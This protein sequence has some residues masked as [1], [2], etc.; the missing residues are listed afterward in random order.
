MLHT[1]LTF[2]IILGVILMFIG[3][4]SAKVVLELSGT[5][6]SVL[7]EALWNRIH[8]NFVYNLYDLG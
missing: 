3:M 1:I 7:D 5:P 8:R 4:L 6:E 2:G